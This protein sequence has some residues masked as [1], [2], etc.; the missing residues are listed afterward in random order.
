M[1]LF[2][3]T[4]PKAE[5]HPMTCPTKANAQQKLLGKVGADLDPSSLMKAYTTASEKGIGTCPA[6]LHHAM[7]L[8]TASARAWRV[9]VAFAANTSSNTSPIF[10][11]GSLRSWIPGWNDF[12]EY[13]KIVFHL[14]IAAALKAV[15]L[16]SQDIFGALFGIFGILRC[17]T[18]SSVSSKTCSTVLLN[19][20]SCLVIAIDCFGNSWKTLGVSNLRSQGILTAGAI[21]FLLACL[22]KSA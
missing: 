5:G 9:E 7:N 20:R 3:S 19:T 15:N 8:T 10:K 16:C 22:T 12:R 14:A 17:D 2:E 18:P 21:I 6:V 4:Q 1:T 13:S 11:W